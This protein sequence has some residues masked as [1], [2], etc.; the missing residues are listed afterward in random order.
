MAN[1]VADTV[2]LSRLG[3]TAEVRASS[4]DEDERTVE[5]TWTTGA[6]VPRRMPGLGRVIEE[7]EVSTSAIRLDRLNN[8]APF[9][10]THA[11]WSLDDVLGVVERAWIEGEEGRA[12]IRF[13][14]REDVEPIWRDVKAGIIRNISVG[15]RTHRYEVIEEEGEPTR[16]IARDW[17][18]TEI[19]AVPIGAD[20]QAGFRADNNENACQLT[21]AT[22]DQSDKET[23]MAEEDIKPGVDPKDDAPESR[24]A[25][26]TPAP[27][28]ELEKKVDVAEVRSAERKRI[29]E[30][31]TVGRKLKIEQSVIDAA[32]ERG[33]SIDTARAA[34]IDAMADDDDEPGEI[35]GNITINRDE[36]ETRR[37]LIEN[38]IEVRLNPAA[39]M[40]EGAGQFRSMSL[41]RIGEELLSARGQSVRGMPRDEMA[42][43]MLERGYHGTSDFTLIL[44]NVASK[45][46][47]AAYEAAPQTFD[48]IVR[49]T[50]VS[51]FKPVNVLTLSD[52]PAFEAM[53]ENAEYKYGTMGEGRETYAL[54]SYGRGISFTR[55]M[56]INDD[57][58][59]FD[60]ITQAIGTS[61]ANLESD[62][63]WGLVTSNPALASGTAVFHADHGNLAT[64]GGITVNNIGAGR[65]LMRN[66]R[67]L[68]PDASTEGTLLNLQPAFLAVPGELET[69]A[70]QHINATSIVTDVTK[71]NVYAN[72][73]GLIVEPRL[74]SNGGSVDDWYLFAS[75]SQVDIIEFAELEGQSGVF[76]D[77]M[78]DF[79]TDGIKIKARREF[80]AAWIDY[81]GAMKNPGS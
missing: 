11:D 3:R 27:A 50:T 51:D 43:K 26:P 7:L 2:Q 30:I 45:R 24:K 18:P 34:F 15:Y 17:E 6:G 73:M 37:N 63:V 53:T 28:P 77:Q 78:V 19:S 33:D 1:D 56:I 23:P 79:D 44:Q 68:A 76:I 80:A 16:V 5:V 75:P 35:R 41:L 57:L 52:F 64:A 31:T 70:R 46:L 47:R 21:R 42:A 81:R 36:N 58:N 4:V 67:S 60:R 61:A 54:A 49:R 65:T 10:N 29:T 48:P 59:A 32:I 20:D 38:A 71:Q 40:L 12:L 66:Q 72:T 14:D 69:V 9:L 39:E 25:D 55:R 22:P 13:S 74:A 62:T 8:G